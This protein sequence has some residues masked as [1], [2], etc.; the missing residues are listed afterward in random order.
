MKKILAFFLVLAMLVPMG[1]IVGAEEAVEAKPFYSLVWG[2]TKTKFDYLEGLVY[3]RFLES[4][5]EAYLY[6]YG[7]S[8]SNVKKMAENFKEA[9]DARP[10][11]TRYL[12]ILNDT[13]AYSLGAEHVVYL[14]KGVATVKRYVERFLKAYSEIGGQLDGIIM[15]TEHLP[16]ESWYL[17]KDSYSANPNLYKE[18]AEDPR[19]DTEIRPMLEERGFKFFKDENGV[20]PELWSIHP[21]AGSGYAVSRTI[22]DHVMRTRIS[23]YINQCIWEPLQEYFPGAH[24]GNYQMADNYGWQKKISNIG[25]NMYV[26]GNLIKSGDTSNLNSYFVQPYDSFYVE[27]GSYVYRDIPAYYQAVIE[28]DSYTMFLWDMHR[29][30]DMYMATD[31]GEVNFWITAYDGY[32]AAQAQNQADTA[33]STP[34]YSEYFFHTAMMDPDMYMIFNPR[35]ER[36]DL[37][38]QQF[39]QRTQ[40]I[41]ECMAEINRLAGFADRKVIML[42]NS[43][44][45][46][47]V[48]SGMYAGGRNIWRITPD[49]TAGMTV[50]DFK[51]EGDDPTF[52]INGK[53]VTFPQGK[54]IADSK[55]SMVGS[56]GYWVETPA[57]VLPI[58]TTDVNRY[59][60]YPSFMEN[61]ERYK[62]GKLTFTDFYPYGTWEPSFNGDDAVVVTENGNK[63]LAITGSTTLTNVK[64]PALVTA[65]DYYAKEQAWEVTVK[66]PANINADAEIILLGYE[67][68]DQ[69][70]TEYGFKISGGKVY[71]DADGEHIDLGVDVSAGGTYTFKRIVNFTDAEAF[72]GEY[73]V[74]DADGKEI[75]S[76]KDVSL[77]VIDLPVYDIYMSCEDLEEQILLDNYKLYPV[78]LTTDFELYNVSGGVLYPDQ[79]SAKAEDT[80]YRLSWLNNSGEY[81]DAVVMKAVYE[82]E[83]LVSE[84]ALTTVTM[85]PGDD[86]VVTGIVEVAEGQSVKLYLKTGESDGS[87]H[88]SNKP[89]NKPGASNN[90][91]LSIGELIPIIII[92][93][94]IMAAAVVLAI[95]LG[96][97]KKSKK[98][99][100]KG[101]K[102]SKKNGKKKT[103]SKAKTSAKPKAEETPVETKAE[104][105]PV[106]TKEEVPAETKEETETPDAE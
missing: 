79:E 91:N 83:T 96:G 86:G 18:I 32:D 30:K 36:K 88:P 87:N 85:A 33:M 12:M 27:S 41:S 5:G 34:Y 89:S 62:E 101:K 106:G 16:V 8:S 76:A 3:L 49:T 15:D 25:G 31:S 46:G 58:E 38:D 92:A 78:G 47:Y 44:N 53:T 52:R 63:M 98:K 66:L 64:M 48:L 54:I 28:K 65:G 81:A 105:T 24:M 20:L 40:V 74:Y 23:M 61:Y 22:W 59:E 103:S 67:D 97:G 95:V 82:G 13:L 11:G 45:N 35:E 6:S 39:D 7:A 102:K 70:T 29:F 93:V 73:Y 100:K 77:T 1:M 14:D 21:Y 26:G 60:M 42:D 9:M 43:W 4:D 55:I 71:Y 80:G 84:E 10:E 75:A 72:T 94:V 99:S 2:G 51:I 50:E 37:T 69:I 57:D 17:Y 56:C 90:G 104:E 19:F 68:N